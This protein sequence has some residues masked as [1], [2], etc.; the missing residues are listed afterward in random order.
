MLKQ[1]SCPSKTIARCFP[2]SSSSQKPG[3]PNHVD[4]MA[5]A[6]ASIMKE[7]LLTRFGG[8]VRPLT[9]QG[10][11]DEINYRKG[12]KSIHKKSVENHQ[13]AGCQLSPRDPSPKS[14]Q[15]REGPPPEDQINADTALRWGHCT[16]LNNFL[17]KNNSTK[18]VDSYPS[19]GRAHTIPPTNLTVQATQQAWAYSGFCTGGGEI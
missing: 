16:F 10:V 5:S 11:I 7:T 18:Y 17:A 12:L 9:P 3:H 6:P 13:A 2:S 4:I 1:R 19:L 15:L 8:N 14:Q